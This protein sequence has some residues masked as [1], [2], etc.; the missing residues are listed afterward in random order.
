MRFLLVL[1]LFFSTVYSAAAARVSIGVL[2]YNGVEQALDRWQPTADYLSQKIPG[3]E[4]EILPLT[5]EAFEH[6]INKGAIDFILTNPGHYVRLEVA[7]GATRIATFKTRYQDQVLTRFSAAIFTRE[8]SGIDSLKALRGKT[9]AAVSEQAFGGFQLAQDA[10]LDEGLDALSSVDLVW[11]GFPHSDIVKAVMAGEA[12]AGVVR[13]GVME[14]M[15]ADGKLNL[16]E[17]KVLAARESPGFPFQ[18]SVDLYPEWPFAK[19]PE[20]SDSLAK[21][22]AIALFQMP[23]DGLSA[24]QAG[25]AGWT[26]PLDYT[27]VHQVLRKL[28]LDPYL[29]VSLSM[30]EFW[31]AYQAWIVAMGFLFLLTLLILLR[32][33]NTNQQL[34]L[35]ESAL[36]RHQQQLEDTVTRRTDELQAL[37]QTLQEDVAYRIQTEQSLNDG[38]ETLQALYG[39]SNR[40]D[41]DRAQRLQS[42]LDL[43]RHFL[44]AEHALLTH[45]KDQKFELCTASPGNKRIATPLNRPCAEAAIVDSQISSQEALPGGGRYVACP[46]FVAGSLHC[47]LEFSSSAS[48]HAEAK[49][50]QMD[51]SSELN[52][53]I[54]K[55]ISQWLGNEVVL[56]E[57]E[58]NIQQR[59]QQLQLRFENI[60]P[61]ERTVLELLVAGESTKS[62]ARILS[63]SPKTVELHRA[64]LLRKTGVKTSIELVKFAVLAGFDGVVE[65]SDA[66]PSAEVSA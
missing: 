7:Y 53:R 60:S 17:V 10:M 27:S 35:S 11:M 51:L 22:V 5:L 66:P 6:G 24:A 1:M 23:E 62:M 47:L 36:H 65:Q 44:G 43:V 59:N 64:N 2:A 4:F 37:N 3:A 48:Y 56:A 14:K 61:R 33:T 63:I 45:Y 30:G 31:D 52:L 38:C 50:A 41:L 28:K 55:L 26:T 46:V 18:H 58:E 25:G 20:T 29:P 9:F 39:I 32:L 34:K 12:D 49:G 40:H 16:S 42:I 15:A 19:L 13:S 8:D 54:L 57:R 21:E